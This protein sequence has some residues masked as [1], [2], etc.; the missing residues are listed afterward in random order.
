M[1]FLK[2]FLK[3]AISSPAKF[4]TSIKNSY[5]RSLK[6][7]ENFWVVVLGWGAGLY[8]GSFIVGALAIT[9]L[10]NFI[11]A[12]NIFETVLLKL[13]PL[14]I[15]W[16]GALGLIL[17]FLYPFIL[18]LALIKCAYP[19]KIY[20]TLGLIFLLVFF[21][22]HYVISLSLAPT[23]IGLIKEMLQSELMSVQVTSIIGII[24]ISALFIYTLINTLKFLNIQRLTNYSNNS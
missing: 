5:F 6:G 16:V 7:E 18:S 9:G 23:S 15:V 11:P 13:W 4:C 10:T 2:N 22:I 19:S 24:S 21:R 1:N 3:S 14:I 8:L 12:H 20:T 17:I